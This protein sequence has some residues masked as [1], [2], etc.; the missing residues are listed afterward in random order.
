MLTS[1]VNDAILANLDARILELTSSMSP[2]IMTEAESIAAGRYLE[3][4]MKSRAD[5]LAQV[6]KYRK[7]FRVIA[8][9]NF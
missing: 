4:L 7:P 1:A 3:Q 2:D 9:H 6:A 5:Y 8:V